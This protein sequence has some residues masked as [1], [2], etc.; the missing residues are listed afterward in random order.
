MIIRICQTMESD[1]GI[2][3]I[4]HRHVKRCLYIDAARLIRFCRSY[5]RA[6][7]IISFSIS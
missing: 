2:L 1:T 5:K 6:A 7:R 3:H 4:E